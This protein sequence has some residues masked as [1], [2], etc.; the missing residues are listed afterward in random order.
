MKKLLIAIIACATLQANAQSTSKSVLRNLK[1]GVSSTI[2]QGLFAPAIDVKQY[3]TLSTKKQT[4]FQPGF[5]VRLTQ[6]SGGHCLL[7]TTAPADITKGSLTSAP[8]LANID[9]FGLDNTG[10]TALN[11]LI[12]LNYH[13]NSKFNVEFNIDLAGFTFGKSQ[14]AYLRNPNGVDSA[15]VSANGSPTAQNLLLVSDRDL[16]SLNS[17][18]VGTYKISNHFRAKLGAGF[19]FSEY[20]FDNPTYVNTSGVTV[21]NNRFRNKTMGIT[22]GGIYNF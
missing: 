6:I 12:A 19:L 17:E 20:S 18:L 11:A 4:R 1:Y 2:A 21:T 9:S 8:I 14:K 13:I 22:I 10:A 5:G 16:G 3:F 7:Y 15:F